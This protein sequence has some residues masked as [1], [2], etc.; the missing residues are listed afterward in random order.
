[1]AI[2][3]AMVIEFTAAGQLRIYTVF[4]FNPFQ[5]NLE[6]NQS[7]A[8]VGDGFVIGNIIL[9]FKVI[10]KTNDIGMELLSKLKKLF[11][12]GDGPA[13]LST[14]FIY[15]YS[16]DAQIK[17]EEIWQNLQKGILLEDRGILIPWNFPFFK[18]E[19]IQEQ[20]R[21]RA[22]RTEWTLEKRT[23][24]DGYE[25]QLETMRWKNIPAENPVKRLTENLGV[26][27]A[28]QE[29]FNLLKNHLTGLLGEATKTELQKFGIYDIGSVSWE[30][31]E[32]GLTLVGIDHFNVRYTFYIGL[33]FTNAIY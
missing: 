3:W 13:E 18:M 15:P 9:S 26:D 20:K 21:E 17:R 8:N 28:G 31:G 4:P 2:E 11:A 25:A 22:D 14:D 23:I 5:L 1:M 30:R 24:L 16:D 32:I 29:H 10:N 27:D 6:R 33:K 12:P 7:A 19:T